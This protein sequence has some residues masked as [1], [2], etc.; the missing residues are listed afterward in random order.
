MEIHV[1]AE[2]NYL[3]LVDGVPDDETNPYR[4]RRGLLSALQDAYAIKRSHPECTVTVQ[5]LFED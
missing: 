3:V 4:G 1:P 5:L 2:F